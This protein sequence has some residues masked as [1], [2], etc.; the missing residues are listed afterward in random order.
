MVIIKSLLRKLPAPI[1]YRVLAWKMRLIGEPECRLL[2]ILVNKDETAIDI[3]GNR[4]SYT[5]WLSKLVPKVYVFEPIPKLAN[6]LREVASSNVEIINSGLS[7]ASGKAEIKIPINNGFQIEGEATLG[8]VH[9]VYDSI[10]V[11]LNTLDCFDYSNIGFIKVD[12]EGH[13]LSVIK[14]GRNLLTNEVPNLLVEIEQR[15]INFPIQTVFNEIL[16][17]GYR[18]YYYQNN[19]LKSLSGFNCKDMQR[20][21]DIGTTKYINNFIFVHPNR[22][23]KQSQKLLSLI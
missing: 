3:G 11:D 17:L 21:A 15:H 12:V 2:N 14:G 7:D 1:L 23:F 18:G 5:F 4:G 10:S 8:D 22:E 16:S 19:L 9:S 20:E 6:F 13:E